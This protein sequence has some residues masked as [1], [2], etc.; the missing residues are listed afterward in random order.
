MPRRPA[1]LLCLLLTWWMAY[2]MAARCEALSLADRTDSAP[3]LSEDA[4][5]AADEAEAKRILNETVEKAVKVAVAP[6]LATIA[7]KD[8]RIDLLDVSLA[9]ETARADAAQA[10]AWAG[11]GAAGGLA[12]GL[13]VALI[14]P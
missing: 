3:Y 7:G 9:A 1:W 14:L 4:Q 11:W 2:P 8:R 13:I 5:D 12:V 6:L 10:W